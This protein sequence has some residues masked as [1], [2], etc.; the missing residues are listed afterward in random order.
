MCLQ[1]LMATDGY[2]SGAATHLRQKLAD[3]LNLATYCAGDLCIGE[4]RDART[5]EALAVYVL[6]DSSC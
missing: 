1:M 5:T 2:A 4:Q 6:F 3:S